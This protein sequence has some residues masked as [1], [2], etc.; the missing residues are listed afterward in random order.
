M[1]TRDHAEE[2]GA[3]V[4][5]VWDMQR[6]DAGEI[7]ALLGGRGKGGRADGDKG[8][9]QAHAGKQCTARHGREFKDSTPHGN[10]K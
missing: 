5:V 6:A 8:A 10:G 4:R 9:Q 1:N 2:A 7:K 3:L